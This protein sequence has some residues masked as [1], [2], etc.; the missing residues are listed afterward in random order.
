MIARRTQPSDVDMASKASFPASD[1]PALHTETKP[2][3]SR[4]EAAEER[5]RRA[6]RTRLPTMPH[7]GRTATLVGLASASALAGLA[8]GF[9]VGRRMR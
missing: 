9:C 1:P 6:R 8:V 5:E 3:L 4:E 7:V 2:P